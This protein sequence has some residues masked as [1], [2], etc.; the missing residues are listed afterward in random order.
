M[1]VSVATR[2]ISREVCCLLHLV[3]QAE[4]NDFSTGPKA[5]L[6]STEIAVHYIME[7]FSP[8]LS[9][10]IMRIKSPFGADVKNFW[11]STTTC[12]Y[13][14]KL[15]YWVKHTGN[16]TFPLQAWNFCT[17]FYDCLGR[18]CTSL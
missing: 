3:A 12:T 5:V 9:G 14:F 16:S 6:P 4:I 7:V 2:R 13:V 15:W 1:S 18:F 11:K 17:N 8:W 10:R